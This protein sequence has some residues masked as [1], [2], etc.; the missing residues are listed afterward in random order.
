MDYKKLNQEAVKCMRDPKDK[1]TIEDLINEFGSKELLR[2]WRKPS[3][4]SA[5]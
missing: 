5:D 3:Y 4:L 2:E 1:R